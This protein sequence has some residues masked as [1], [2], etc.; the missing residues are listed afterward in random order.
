MIQEER[1]LQRQK[2]EGVGIHDPR[3]FHDVDV[4]CG[5]AGCD[6][7]YDYLLDEPPVAREA[8]EEGGIFLNVWSW[9][10]VP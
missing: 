4:F 2:T 7:G 1:V 3:I 10:C 9:G 8:D 6:V 5:P